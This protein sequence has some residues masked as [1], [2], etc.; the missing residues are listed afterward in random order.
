MDDD[1]ELDVEFPFVG[2]PCDGCGGEAEVRV[3]LDSGSDLVLCHICWH[4]HEAV[5]RKTVAAV[6]GW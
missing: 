6:R 5:L 4:K 3:V 2:E 1:D